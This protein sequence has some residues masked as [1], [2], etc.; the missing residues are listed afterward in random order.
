MGGDN[1]RD[2]YIRK[3]RGYQERLNR[4]FRKDRLAEQM[5]DPPYEKAIRIA[6]VAILRIPESATKYKS[7]LDWWFKAG[8][9]KPSDPAGW[10][11]ISA[12]GGAWRGVEAISDVD[13]D[14]LSKSERKLIRSWLLCLP[15]SLGD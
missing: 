6:G 4:V 13:W 10:S 3:L 14:A 8:R 9:L 2:E 1:S 15:V 7:F 12:P 5:F 11:T